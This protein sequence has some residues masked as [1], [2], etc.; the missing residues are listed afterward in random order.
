MI[1]RIVD[2][3]LHNPRWQ[4]DLAQ[5]FQHPLPIPV[6]IRFIVEDQFHIGESEQR[7]R[8]QMHDMRN[9]VHHGFQRNRDLLFDLFG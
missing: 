8:A 5:P 7:K 2:F 3:A 4:R 9:A 1:R 6:V